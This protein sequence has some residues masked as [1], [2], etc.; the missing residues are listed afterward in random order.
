MCHICS[1]SLANNRMTHVTTWCFSLRSIA[2][3][4]LLSLN[5]PN[6]LFMFTRHN[7][8]AGIPFLQCVCVYDCYYVNLILETLTEAGPTTEA[9]LSTM[10]GAYVSTTKNKTC[11]HFLLLSRNEA[12]I[13]QIR[14]LPSCAFRARVC[15]VAR[16]ARWM[17]STNH[18]SVSAVSPDV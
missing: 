18:K 12:K 8:R 4:P 2:L 3:G 10:V 1:C 13:V 5:I 7:S 6:G 15:T 11:L 17:C 14:K 9:I 16:S